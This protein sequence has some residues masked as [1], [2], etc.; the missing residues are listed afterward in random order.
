[1]TKNFNIEIMKNGFVI[2]FQRLTIFINSL[3]N[4]LI[5]EFLSFLSYF[6]NINDNNRESSNFENSSD[7]F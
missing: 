4:S 7:G 1:M 2:Q 6:I 3:I 5:A